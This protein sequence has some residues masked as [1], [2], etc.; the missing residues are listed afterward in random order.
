MLDLSAGDEAKMGGIGDT[1]GAV[2]EP[3]TG[4]VA[5]YTGTSLLALKGDPTTVARPLC[6]TSS[7]S[8]LFSHLLLSQS[9]TGK[10]NERN[11]VR[12]VG[13]DMN[14]VRVLWLCDNDVN[15]LIIL[16]ASNLQLE[17][18]SLGSYRCVAHVCVGDLEVC[19]SHFSP[20]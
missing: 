2:S 8:A 9:L 18:P 16:S 17:Y 3:Q 1:S 11:P 5:R 19:P 14:H 15:D 6:S 7:Y 12:R 13:I 4:P 20:I 10:T